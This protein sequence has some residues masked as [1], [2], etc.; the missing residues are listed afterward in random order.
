[1][2]HPEWQQ[3]ALD[4]PHAARAIDALHP[5]LKIIMPNFGDKMFAEKQYDNAMMRPYQR[6]RKKPD[7]T[8]E[9]QRRSER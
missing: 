5:N 6:L 1:M 7:S 3:I 4:L 2:S 8:S 9:R